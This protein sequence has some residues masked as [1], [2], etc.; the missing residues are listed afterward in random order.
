MEKAA[1][2]DTSRVSSTVAAGLHS[3]PTVPSLPNTVVHV[4]LDAAN[5]V[6]LVREP[7]PTAT[8]ERAQLISKM[9]L[10]LLPVREED[11]EEQLL[12][13]SLVDITP[14]TLSL[15]HAKLAAS[16]RKRIVEHYFRLLCVAIFFILGTV[17]VVVL[18]CVF[19]LKEN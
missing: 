19:A 10:P 8:V 4:H 11:S 3:W 2:L 6:P 18:V 12:H 14:D 7:G 5:T 1:S 9:R 17:C 15:M 16:T 13:T